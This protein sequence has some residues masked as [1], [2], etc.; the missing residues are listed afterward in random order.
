MVSQAQRA[1][2]R[3]P[4]PMIETAQNPE[5]PKRLKWPRLALWILLAIAALSLALLLCG[6]VPQV[7]D[8]L[9][10]VGYA[11]FFTNVLGVLAT[12]IGLSIAGLLTAEQLDLERLD[13]SKD[14]RLSAKRDV[15]MDVI[16]GLNKMLGQF[17]RLASIE[18]EQ[19]EIGKSFGEGFSQAAPGWAVADLPTVA[20]L[21]KLINEASIEFIELSKERA[22]LVA[23]H[24]EAE[25]W[26]KVLDASNVDNQHLFRMQ[27]DATGAGRE[28]EA[29]RWSELYQLAVRQ[30]PE[31]RND[32]DKAR[33]ALDDQRIPYLV[34]CIFIH[35]RLRTE[36]RRLISRIRTEIEVDNPG[37]DGYLAFDLAADLEDSKFVRH[38]MQTFNQHHELIIQEARKSGC[39]LEDPK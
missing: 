1:T 3:Y 27:T 22:P 29:K 16:R 38:L 20:L 36:Y 5:L 8:N 24:D 34:K 28:N 35:R 17:V 4:W 26:E 11:E 7:I 19:N 33:N 21:Q 23:L 15:L 37:V 2:T 9:T 18:V 30:M 32:R 31:I 14:R 13:R 39:K 10:D 25:T 12:V 6:Y